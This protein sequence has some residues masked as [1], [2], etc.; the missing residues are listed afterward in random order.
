MFSE[1]GNRVTLRNYFKG[2]GGVVG[3]KLIVWG[4]WLVYWLSANESSKEDLLAWGC[5]KIRLK[6]NTWLRKGSPKGPSKNDVIRGWREGGKQKFKKKVTL[7][8]KIA[9][10]F[11]FMVT[12]ERGR[13][14][15]GSFCSDII[16]WMAPKSFLIPPSS[17]KI[18]L[19]IS[20]NGWNS[21]WTFHKSLE[22]FFLTNHPCV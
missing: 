13:S 19:S 20:P 8:F 16:F 2:L 5:I 22:K 18:R 14:E 11:V 4:S 12:R 21:N 10:S 15:N 6:K 9:N 3:L 7:L 1:Q 17:E